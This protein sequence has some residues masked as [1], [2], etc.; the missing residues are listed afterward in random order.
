M[1]IIN[2]LNNLIIQVKQKILGNQSQKDINERRKTLLNE[3]ERTEK[4]LKEIHLPQLNVYFTVLYDPDSFFSDDSLNRMT[5]VLLFLNE[6]DKLLIDGRKK[7]TVNIFE[8]SVS[9]QFL[10]LF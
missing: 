2:R 6:I 4:N 7:L 3:Y 10:R 5:N 1:P 8:D 9:S